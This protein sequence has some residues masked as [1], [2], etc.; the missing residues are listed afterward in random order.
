MF[1]L[2]GCRRNK[3]Y[4]FNSFKIALYSAYLKSLLMHFS[5]SLIHE[6]PILGMTGFHDLS[7][8]LCNDVVNIITVSPNSTCINSSLVPRRRNISS[9]ICYNILQL[10][11]TA[12]GYLLLPG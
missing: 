10:L 1:L 8:M 9:Q 11:S 4:D 7:F 5:Q 3:S 2:G 6:G 12:L